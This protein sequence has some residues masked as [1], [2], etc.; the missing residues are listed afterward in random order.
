MKIRSAFFLG[1]GSGLNLFLKGEIRIQV[2]STRN[3]YTLVYIDGA[4]LEDIL[5]KPQKGDVPF[6]VD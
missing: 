6:L 1:G 2:I 4:I 5:G 3:Y